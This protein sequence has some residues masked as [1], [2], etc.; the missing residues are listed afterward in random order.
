MEGSNFTR[1][2]ICW[3]TF[4]YILSN[5]EKQGK[6]PPLIFFFEKGIYRAVNPPGHQILRIDREGMI[7]D[8]ILHDK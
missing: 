1:V 2:Y 8:V 6:V 4:N 3:V 7:D 5:M